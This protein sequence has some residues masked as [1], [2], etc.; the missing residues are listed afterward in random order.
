MGPSASLDFG[1]RCL[2]VLAAPIVRVPIWKDVLVEVVAIDALPRL[3]EFDGR[4]GFIHDAV[5]TDLHFASA[6][7]QVDRRVENVL[8]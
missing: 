4:I 3:V 6:V 5:S 8:L 7:R 1:G 2:E